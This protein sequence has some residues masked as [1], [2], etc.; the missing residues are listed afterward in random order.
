MLIRQ[1]NAE[2]QILQGF[3]VLAEPNLL[4]YTQHQQLFVP[5]QTKIH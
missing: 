3:V 4:A 2:L 1:A 5:I